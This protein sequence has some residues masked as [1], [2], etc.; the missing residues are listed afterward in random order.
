MNVDDSSGKAVWRRPMFIVV[1]RDDCAA[2]A[3][4]ALATD[5]AA[6]GASS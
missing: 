2:V 1:R 3:R 4:P 6:N 5:P